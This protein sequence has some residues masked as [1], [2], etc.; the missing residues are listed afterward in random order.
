MIDSSGPEA[1]LGTQADG[2]ANNSNSA[3]ALAVS[4]AVPC[5]P[6]GVDEVAS[7]NFLNTSKNVYFGGVCASAI[8]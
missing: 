8:F 4:R 6:C 2:A 5:G 1:P 3:D 7:S